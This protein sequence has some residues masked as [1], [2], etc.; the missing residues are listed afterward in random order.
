MKWT[1][2]SSA[3]EH[4]HSLLVLHQMQCRGCHS[5]SKHFY[6]VLGFGCSSICSLVFPPKK[7]LLYSH[8]IHPDVLIRQDLQCQ[9]LPRRSGSRAAWGSIARAKCIQHQC[10]PIS[11]RLNL[12]RERG[13]HCTALLTD[14]CFGNMSITC[15]LL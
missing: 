13:A 5:S 12:M 15:F 7:T 1:T 6:L 14:C 2:R 11:S 8:S 10:L 4:I 9:L 3:L